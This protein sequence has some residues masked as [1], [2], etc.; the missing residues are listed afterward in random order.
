DDL[1]LL[2]TYEPVLRFT[3]GELFFPFSAE[4]YIRRCSLWSVPDRGE[5][6]LIVPEG[7]LTEERLAQFGMAP[8]GHTY[9]LRF[10]E[11]PLRGR[12]FSRWYLREE[13]P[14]FDARGRLARVGLGVRALDSLFE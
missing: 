10:V 14:V 11:E 4:S 12:A 8:P 3:Y 1:T 5:P 9:Y 7:Q 6:E 2:R 13:R